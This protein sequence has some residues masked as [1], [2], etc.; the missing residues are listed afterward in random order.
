MKYVRGVFSGGFYVDDSRHLMG[1]F[2]GMVT[3]SIWWWILVGGSK[4]LSVLAKWW[5]SIHFFDFGGK[6][7]CEVL[8]KCMRHLDMRFLEW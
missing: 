1:D 6:K 5:W 7:E 8:G 3:V 4:C 2:H